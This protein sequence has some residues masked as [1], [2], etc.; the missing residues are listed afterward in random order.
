ML[1]KKSRTL[2][3]T[4]YS[5]KKKSKILKIV[6]QF[7]DKKRPV[8]KQ[9][10]VF[11]IIIIFKLLRLVYNNVIKESL[12]LLLS[13]FLRLYESLTIFLLLFKFK[14]NVKKLMRY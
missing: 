12:N 3:L 6:Q 7:F 14:L 9:K 2:W 10:L 8:K 4:I 1:L 11:Q 13:I 5:V